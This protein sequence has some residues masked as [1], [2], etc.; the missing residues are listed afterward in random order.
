MNKPKHLKLLKHD[1]YATAPSKQP[2]W[3]SP[4]WKVMFNGIFIDNL[5]TKARAANL[6][7]T[8]K[9]AL[10]RGPPVPRDKA[11]ERLVKRLVGE[12]TS[13]LA[14]EVGHTEKQLA[15]YRDALAAENET[16]LKAPID[17]S[18]KNIAMAG[19]PA[20]YLLA[21][22]LVYKNE[23]DALKSE[24]ATIHVR[25]KAFQDRILAGPSSIDEEDTGEHPNMEA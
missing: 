16:A 7:R 10:R 6:I 3:T 2:G 13:R 17:D 15:R 5:P 12:A 11:V 14:K 22:A 4:G 19:S 18:T 8:L 25:L 20:G 23:R 24:L 21:V 1:L 9:E